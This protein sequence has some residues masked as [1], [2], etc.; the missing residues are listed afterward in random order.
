MKTFVRMITKSIDSLFATK[1]WLPPGG[2]ISFSSCGFDCHWRS[3]DCRE[4]Y[5]G[6]QECQGGR[7]QSRLQQAARRRQTHQGGNEGCAAR[8]TETESA[9]DKGLWER[10]GC[11]RESCSSSTRQD[12]VA[13]YEHNFRMR[14]KFQ[15]A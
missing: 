1:P 8:R 6:N 13:N 14:M 11:A 3:Y 9:S 10:L 4:E 5:E 12:K 7:S 2:S 15:L